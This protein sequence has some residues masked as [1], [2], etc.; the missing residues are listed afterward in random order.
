M[1]MFRTSNPVYRSVENAFVSD[2]PVTY[3]GVGFK[4]MLMLSVTASIG[5]YVYLNLAA[6][7]VPLLI[8]AM[9][10]GF[11]AVI[12][13]TRSVRLSPYFALLYAAC[14]GIIIGTIS[15]LA[16]AVY[17]GIVPTAVMTTVIVFFIT[18]LLYSTN[19]I[20]VNQRFLSFVVVAMISVIIM[21]L[22]GIFL[23]F[24]GGLYT[25]VALA[26]AVLATLY[27]FIDFERIKMCVESGTDTSYG[28]ILS[29]GL[30]VSLIW[31]YVDILRLLMIFGRNR[32]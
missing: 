18:M 13:G 19:I 3:A 8:G 28:W 27:L 26:S 29:L 16:T 25:I 2:R 32:R 9:I 14:E 1:R 7:S 15:S 30:M 17:G 31:L 21:S 22:I 12:V 24:G 5:Y 4:T 10:V 11:I 23:P 6:V 20:K